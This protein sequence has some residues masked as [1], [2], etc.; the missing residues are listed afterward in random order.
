M[1]VKASDCKTLHLSRNQRFFVFCKVTQC[2]IILFKAKL[3]KPSN[4]FI[5]ENTVTQMLTQVHIR[6]SIE[7]AMQ[8]HKFTTKYIRARQYGK[9]LRD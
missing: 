5:V 2:A 8:S 7:V 9:M 3:P 6:W 4:K 1:F